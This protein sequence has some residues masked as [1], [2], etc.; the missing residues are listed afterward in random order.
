MVGGHHNMPN[1]TKGPQRQEG[2]VTTVHVEEEQEPEWSELGPEY[3]LQ[4]PYPLQCA[5]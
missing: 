3:N 5:S 4:K 1:C 2:E